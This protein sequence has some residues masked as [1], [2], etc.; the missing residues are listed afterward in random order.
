M[1]RLI[2]PLAL[3]LSICSPLALAHFAAQ[4]DKSGERADFIRVLSAQPLYETMEYPFPEMDCGLSLSPARPDIPAPI[5]TAF[6]APKAPVDCR[7]RAE[8]AEEVVAYRV[9][10]RYHG[11]DYITEMPYDPG[12]R[13]PVDFDVQPIRW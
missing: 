11:H 4:K 8:R 10:Y 6:G 7:A 9:H 1:I 12:S 5:A 2:F 3:L 13:L